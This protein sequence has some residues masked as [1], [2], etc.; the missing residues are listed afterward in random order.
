M[1]VREIQERL[2]PAAT[3]FGSEGVSCCVSFL[4]EISPDAQNYMTFAKKKK[5]LLNRSL[6]VNEP[7]FQ[8]L[9][10]ALLT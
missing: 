10:C 3:T 2:S 1:S 4:R 6:W 7:N 9:L 5:F 8:H